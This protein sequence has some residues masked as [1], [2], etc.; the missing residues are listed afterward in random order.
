ML[1]RGEIYY[2]DLGD[3]LGSEQGGKRPVLIVQNDV[4]NFYSPTTIVLPFTSAW[5]KPLPTHAELVPECGLK[6]HSTA[7]AEQIRTIDRKS[8]LNYV[9]YL[10][11]EEMLP[12]DRAILTAI[13]VNKNEAVRTG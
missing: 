4:G 6:W 13:G 7:L 3:V 1:R 10:Y 12:V 11:P 8:L 2:A 5:N 9:G